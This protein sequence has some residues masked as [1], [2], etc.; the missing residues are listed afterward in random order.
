MKIRRTIKWVSFSPT[1]INNEFHLTYESNITFISFF[2]LD[3]SLQKA[4]ERYFGPRFRTIKH[5]HIFQIDR[6]LF[7]NISKILFR[8][9]ALMLALCII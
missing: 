2:V 7:W 6:N 8:M 9:N 3:I 5:Q 1:P 4:F